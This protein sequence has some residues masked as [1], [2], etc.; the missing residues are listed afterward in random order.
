MLERTKKWLRLKWSLWKF[1]MPAFVNA[2]LSL[3]CYTVG[4][5]RSTTASA[6]PFSRAGAAATIIAVLIGVY[7]Y[8][9]ALKD[10]ERTVTRA[11]E[12]ITDALPITG[13]ASLKNVTDQLQHNTRRAELTITII[14]V[15]I[16]VLATLIWGFGD[17]ASRW[18]RDT[19]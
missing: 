18:M 1:A 13:K 8:K 9:K 16:L 6:L 15:G 14:Q 2:L 11:F 7:D 5:I 4:W 17:L 12:K 10:S 3:A 19:P